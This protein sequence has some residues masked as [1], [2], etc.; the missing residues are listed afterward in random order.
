MG[1]IVDES[2]LDILFREA[3]TYSRWQARPVADQ[4]LRDLYEILKWAPTSANAA[5]SRYAV[6]RT[7][8]TM[9]PAGLTWN[10]GTASVEKATRSKSQTPD[11]PSMTHAPRRLQI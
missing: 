10:V 4:T 7:K 3:R 2:G 11:T 6:V 8:G 5:P 1:Q 9:G